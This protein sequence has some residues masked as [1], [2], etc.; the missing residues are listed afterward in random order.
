M[1]ATT[2]SPTMGG[3]VHAA[4]DAKATPATAFKAFQVSRCVI[5]SLVLPSAMR[6]C[7]GTAPSSAVVRMNSNCLRSGR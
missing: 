3:G 1:T 6:N 2:D 5:E 4:P 7:T